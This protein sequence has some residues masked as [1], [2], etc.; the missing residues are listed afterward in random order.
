VLEKLGRKYPPPSRRIGDTDVLESNPSYY[1]IL[2]RFIQP[3]SIISDEMSRDV[4]IDIITR[5]KMG[6]AMFLSQD[7]I[8]EFL[9]RSV[10]KAEAFQKIVDG[11]IAIFSGKAAPGSMGD[12]ATLRRTVEGFTV[13]LQDELDRLATFTVTQKGNLDIH[14]LVKG[15]SSGYP[16]SV[17]ELTDDF[18]VKE[19]DYS[20]RCL[21][22]ELPT[23]S[24][25]HILRA[26]EIGIK[27]YLH[28]KA[29]SLPKMNQRNWG[30]YIRQL[31]LANAD[32]DLIDVLKVLKTKRNPLMHPQDSLEIPD[33]IGLFCICQAG[34]EALVANVRK[35]S[36]D[37]KFKDSLKVLPTL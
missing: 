22:F 32:S 2:G 28:A 15:A 1:W 36:L 13:S 35:D 6:L 37:T 17:L 5:A 3:L 26:V 7:V 27:G 23:S 16:S 25:F 4:Q 31:E 33:A 12:F 24:G 20:G 9:P 10:E 19:I 29:G 21:A 14:K 30:E 11:W 18:M 34:I 8:A